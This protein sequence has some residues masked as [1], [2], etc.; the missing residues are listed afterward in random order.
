MNGV[1]PDSI[2][3]VDDEQQVLDG[4][5]RQFRTHRRNWDTRFAL[6]GAEALQMMNERP[7]D[8]IVTDMRM[9]GMNGVALLHEVRERWPGT[10]RL[11][12]SGQTEQ[13]ELLDDIGAVHQFLHKPCETVLIV[14]AVNRAMK[15]AST[16]STK[17]LRELATGLESLPVVSD[18]YQELLTALDNS[19]SD[20][21]T[22]AAV[23]SRDIGL[24]TKLLQMV[25]SA[26]FAMPRPVS[27][28]HDA[29]L[30]LGLSNLRALVIT[31]QI[32]KTMAN[33]AEHDEEL[34]QL[35]RASTDIGASAYM[36]AKQHGQS[37]S[38][39]EGARLAGLLSLVGRSVFVYG[40]P[41]RFARAQERALKE[42]RPLYECEHEE[43]GTA[44][45]TI[46]AYALGLWAFGREILEAVSAQVVPWDADVDTIEHPLAFVHA[47]RS[48]IAVPGLVERLELDEDWLRS[49]GFETWKIPFDDGP[50]EPEF[51]QAS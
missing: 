8:A 37:A 2:I 7:A 28:A 46:G 9:P 24:S 35:W 1:K 30:M 21:E 16:I 39:C 25:N 48:R 18:T 26:F 23:V 5:K 33:Q 51:K 13:S 19:A 17:P 14:Q 32:F 31:A 47:A 36:L 20:I 40:A 42:E 41:A 50:E 45:H 11:I 6:S 4:I 12:L 38:V 15:M 43:I 49:I 34:T 3:F 44:Q 29:V 22:I 27:S 10:V